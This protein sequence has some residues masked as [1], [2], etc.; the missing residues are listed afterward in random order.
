M[1]NVCDFICENLDIMLNWIQYHNVKD[2]HQIYLTFQ[3]KSSLI[4]VYFL[5]DG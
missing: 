1:E 2:L 3:L 4:V 5:E